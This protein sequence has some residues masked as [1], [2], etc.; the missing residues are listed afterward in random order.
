MFALR[1]SPQVR[2]N[3]AD[4]AKI[5]GSPTPSAFAREIITTMVSGDMEKVKAFNARL[6]AGVGEQLTLRLNATLDDAAAIASNA[7]KRPKKATKPPV[8][9]KR[10]GNARKRA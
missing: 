7:K 10:R 2:Q 1:L 3:L 6:I 9:G 8:K 5:Y 4:M